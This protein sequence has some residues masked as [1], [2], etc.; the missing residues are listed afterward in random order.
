MTLRITSIIA[1]CVLL[2][3]AYK[4]DDGAKRIWSNEEKPILA[5]AKNTKEL[6]QLV[7]FPARL[8][9]LDNAQDVHPSSLTKDVEDLSPA[10]KARYVVN[11]ADWAAIATIS[12]RKNVESYPVA[13][14][15]SI[16]D[17]PVGSG[18]GIPYMYF[19]PRAYSSQDLQKDHRATLLMTLAQ[20]DYCKNKGY[21]PLDPRCVR[22]MLTGKIVALKNGTKEHDAVEQFFFSRHPEIKSAPKN[23]ENYP[24]KL[25]ISAIAMLDDFG[26]AK[27]ISVEDYF[28]PSSSINQPLY[29][30][31]FGE[32]LLMNLLPNSMLSN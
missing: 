24:A 10:L 11:Q 20:G 28:N 30:S 25:K 5:V 13:N 4:F 22:V 9:W 23:H 21:D 16:A 27:Y 26:G 1:L 14:V 32:R 29:Y 31:T 19:T 15:I 3:D 17:G 8:L 7:E 18:T 6:Y 2:N 12:T